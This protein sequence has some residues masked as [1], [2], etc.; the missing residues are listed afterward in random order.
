MIHNQEA[1]QA[2]LGTIL[3]EGEVMKDVTLSPEHFYIPNHQ[4]I[5]VAMQ[6]IYKRQEPINLVTVTTELK[7]K[8]NVVGGVSYLSQLVESIPTVVTLKPHQRLVYDAFRNR[9]TREV[10]VDY[11]NNPSGVALEDLMIKLE[12]Y[13]E[14]GVSK[15][16]PSTYEAL[17]EIAREI[18][19]PPE[20]NMT[21][22]STGYHDLDQMTGGTQR[23][24]LIVLAARPSMG[25]TAFALNIAANH[26]KA[27]NSVHLF[28]LEMGMKS[29]LQRLIS[30]EGKINAQ[31]WRTMTFS[32][33][34]YTRTMD[35]IGG[36]AQWP[37]HVHESERT[38]SD[39]RAVVRDTVKNEE[40][41]SRP[42]I[43]IDYLQ[44]M[45]ATGRA[46]NRNIEVGMITRDLKMLA[47][48]LNVPIMVLSQLSRAV[49][50][51]KDKRPVLSDLRESGNIEQDAD[52]IAFL[53]RDDYYNWDSDAG[54]EVELL[55]SKQRNGPIGTVRLEFMKE[56]GR[57][58]GVVSH[59]KS[60][61]GI[62]SL[63]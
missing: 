25:K 26:C 44:L 27:G 37:I 38:V 19:H 2:V 42:L 36:M 50:Q 13:R 52:V 20:G 17:M 34:D 23:G 51:R 53:H 41:D 18:A 10:A 11:V 21:G 12:E 33:R 32:E 16:N 60:S 14:L 40:S 55:L 35:V 4:M 43:I 59:R 30:S 56:Y 57:F 49:E 46:E 3:L 28:S 24:D 15:K 58:E 54:G 8:I 48:E 22:F 31:K 9:K 6:S 45:S 5:Y 61:P 47:R 1:E 62:L 7:E 39:I 29:L 63:G